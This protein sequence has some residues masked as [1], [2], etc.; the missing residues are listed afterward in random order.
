MRLSV[1]EVL[2]KGDTAGVRLAISP[3]E[4]TKRGLRRNTTN[5][6]L[7]PLTRRQQGYLLLTGIHKQETPP[8]RRR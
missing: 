8:G 1:S 5:Q 7:F 4:K 6:V 3:S 2:P